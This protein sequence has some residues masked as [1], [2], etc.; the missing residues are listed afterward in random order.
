MA[1]LTR[2]SIWNLIGNGAPLLVGIV[3][4]PIIIDDLGVDRFGVLALVWTLVGYFGLFDLG[5]GRAVTHA[6]ADAI[7]TKQRARVPGIVTSG[8]I[9]TAGIGILGMTLVLVGKGALVE[10]VIR[11]PQALADEV[12]LAMTGVAIGI[13][14]VTL[15]SGLRGVLEGYQRF[16]LVNYAR[17]P[18]GVW[19]FICPLFV[20]DTVQP[21]AWTTFLLVAGR[22][23]TV[24]LYWFYCHRVADLEAG[25]AKITGGQTKTLLAF[26][27]WLTVTNVVGPVLVHVDRFVISAILGVHAVAYYVTPFEV[28]SRTTILASALSFALFP[29]FAGKFARDL[30][31]ARETYSL[32]LRTLA[33]LIFPLYLAIVVLA[34]PALLVWLGEDFMLASTVPMQL[35]AIGV[36]VNSVAHVPFTLVQSGGRPDWP[37]KLHMV[38]LVV[39]LFFVTYMTTRFGI[40]GAALAWLT[41]IMVDIAIHFRFVEALF[42]SVRVMG[43]KTTLV[44]TGYVAV[45]ILVT[46][47]P[48]DGGTRIV[49]GLAGMALWL[50][51]HRVL[52]GKDER[53]M[54]ISKFVANVAFSKK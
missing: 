14:I 29:S 5:V 18:L 7:A 36:Y 8:L 40:V 17:L 33:F 12:M 2:N 54:I 30:D 44:L 22:L 4:I 50:A 34:E 6:V 20:L 11:P 25:P 42:P 23:V 10:S 1:G 52:F 35:L 46:V 24:L 9:F 15:A 48:T 47:L 39:Y 26:G 28:I 53:S 19:T 45:L 41:R 31:G 32:A 27:G 16:N 37:A 38:E 21:L 43:L 13:P 49:A 3:T 51:S